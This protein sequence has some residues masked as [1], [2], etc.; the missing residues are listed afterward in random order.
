MALVPGSTT[1]IFCTSPFGIATSTDEGESWDY[2][3]FPKFNE[4]D[5]RS[6]CRGVAL[7]EDDSNTMFVGNGDFIPG[8]VG[9]IQTSKDGGKS[10]APAD[11]PV[12]PNSVVYW[13]AT[14]HQLPETI[15]AGSLYGYVYV[16]EDGGDSW[17][18]LKR[19]FGEIRSLALMPQ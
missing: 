16:T 1:S 5:I 14:N 15:V 3:Y 4:A 17:R 11:L 18:K 6:Y 12:E 7:K 10:W 9:A 2:H 13:F 19:E 8:V